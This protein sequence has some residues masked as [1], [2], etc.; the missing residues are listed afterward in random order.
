MPKPIELTDEDI[1]RFWGFVDITNPDGCWYWL[2][3]TDKDGYG[4]FELK[5]T[6]GVWKPFRA[7]RISCHIYHGTAGNM[8]C[9]TCV[10]NP[11]C[12]NPHHL[13]PG[14]GR[15][16]SNDRDKAGNTT[17]VSVLINQF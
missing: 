16:N 8:T 5:D 6:K 13:Y 2:G 10:G 17:R 7:H 4:I 14:T 12:V 9:H 11:S 15:T 3:G 1:A